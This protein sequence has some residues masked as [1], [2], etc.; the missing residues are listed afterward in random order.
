[1][2]DV[3]PLKLADVG[4]GEGEL[5]EFG[6]ADVF[7]SAPVL[8]ALTGQGASGDW[9]TYGGSANALVLTPSGAPARA[10]YRAGD[11]Y[12][13]RATT[14]NTGG[15]TANI[16]GLGVK[17]LVTV[18]GVALPAGYIR[19]DVH[20]VITYDATGDRF[21]VDRQ[22]ERGINATGLYVR[23]ADGTQFCSASAS[24]ASIAA[25]TSGVATLNS[26]AAFVNTAWRVLA[27]AGPAASND[28]YGVTNPYATSTTQMQAIVRNGATAQSFEIRFLG[29]G[30]WY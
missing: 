14:T 24:S 12:R 21:V 15:A 20:T 26:P 30:S 16:A 29:F 8:G 25:N 19:T 13:F 7:P 22:I 28:H 9:C 11:E 4:G 27:S 3:L 18:T 2:P 23:Y 10:A 17:T 5:R 6:A 1:M